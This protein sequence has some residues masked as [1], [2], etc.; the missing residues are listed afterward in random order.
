MK[1]SFIKPKKKSLLRPNTKAWSITFI[2]SFLLMLIFELVLYFKGSL[3]LSDTSSYMQNREEIIKEII[4][5]DDQ[6]AI[7]E[8]K[9][10]FAQEIIDQNRLLNESITNLFALIPDQITLHSVD[11]QKKM[12]VLKGVTPSKEVYTYL[13]S[14]PLK[15]V[16][17]ESTVNFYQTS[18]SWYNFVSVNRIKEE[19]RVE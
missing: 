17:S 3:M 6:I 13:L 7:L 15:S 19:E 10:E 5:I 11:I 18:D 8:A 16:F 1:L 2:A 14:V 9:R 4:K 12:L